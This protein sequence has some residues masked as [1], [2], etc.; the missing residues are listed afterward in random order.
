MVGNYKSGLSFKRLTTLVNFPELTKKRKL[1]LQMV[2]SI[3][4]YPN[5]YDFTINHHSNDC[6]LLEKEI[7]NFS[8]KRNCFRNAKAHRTMQ[9]VGYISAVTKTLLCVRWKASLTVEAAMIMPFFVLFFVLF[10]ALF[11]VLMTETQMNQALSYTVSKVAMESGRFVSEA[12]NL[13]VKKMLIEQLK[14]QGCKEERI[15]DGWE[16]IICVPVSAGELVRINVIYD[17][18]LPFHVFGT[19]EILVSQSAAARRWSGRK[20][21]ESSYTHWVYITPFGAAYHKNI[22]CSYLD[23]SVWSLLENQV[24]DA[25]NKAGG[26]Y[27]PCLLCKDDTVV[28]GD[29]TTVYV[30]DYGRLYHYSLSCSSIKRTVWRVMKENA[31]SRYP[32]QKCN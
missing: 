18:A 1:S 3:S 12:E 10:L 5:Q 31:G 7:I 15:V 27:A 30:T 16:G 28:S 29:D 32:C 25:R 8:K 4:K 26:R 9:P 21:T 2:S 14:M 11:Q 22:S 23:L 6:L 17:V 13:A 20:T 24:S 19:Q